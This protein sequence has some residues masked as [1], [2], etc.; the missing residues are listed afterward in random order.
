MA[1]ACA[2]SKPI[3]TNNNSNGR[4]YALAAPNA[5]PP[6]PALP[7][8]PCASSHSPASSPGPTGGQT[9][10]ARAMPASAISTNPRR[11]ALPRIVRVVASRFRC[12]ENHVPAAPNRFIGPPARRSGPIIAAGCRRSAPSRASRAAACMTCMPQRHSGRHSR[13]ARDQ[14]RIGRGSNSDKTTA[15]IPSDFAKSM[16][17]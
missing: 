15:P 5:Y 11:I 7:R 4:G 14:V 13:Y 3:G 16:D 10:A 17:Q 8:S 12:A 9:R 1:T 6:A 2:F